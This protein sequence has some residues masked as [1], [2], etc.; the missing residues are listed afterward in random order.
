MQAAV[1]IGDT[2]ILGLSAIDSI[3]QN[4]STVDAVRGHTLTAV[5]AARAGGDTGNDDIVPWFESHNTVTDGLY[6]GDAFVA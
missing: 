1:S 5:L 4:P 2:D 3:P 6:D